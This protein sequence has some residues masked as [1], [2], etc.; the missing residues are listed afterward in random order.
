M[1]T[2]TILLIAALLIMPFALS[3][4]NTVDGF[5]RD[6]QNAGESIQKI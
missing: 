5:G 2:K 4:C 3:A 6:L 1:K